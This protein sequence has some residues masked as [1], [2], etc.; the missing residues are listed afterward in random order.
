MDARTARVVRRPD[1]YASML[2][3]MALIGDQLSK[4][5]LQGTIECPSVLVRAWRGRGHVLS[6]G[7]GRYHGVVRHR[8]LAT[9]KKPNSRLIGAQTRRCCLV[10]KKRKRTIKPLGTLAQEF[11]LLAKAERS[12]IRR[13]ERQITR[14]RW[15]SLSRMPE[16]CWR[17]LPNCQLQT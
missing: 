4:P 10:G 9:V 5:L 1:L 6:V 11:Y 17:Y 16:L 12:Y 14:D 3:L 8:F 7:K 15:L 13:Q 2:E